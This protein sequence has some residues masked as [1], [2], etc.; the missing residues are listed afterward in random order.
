[1]PA[2]N[3]Y[4]VARQVTDEIF[5][6]GSYA[7]MNKHHPDPGVQ[8]TIRNSGANMAEVEEDRPFV[9]MASELKLL[10]ID[11]GL[12][13]GHLSTQRLVWSHEV[14]D[15]MTDDPPDT[16]IIKALD[17]YKRRGGT[18]DYAE[19]DF[20]KALVAEVERMCNGS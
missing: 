20:N 9:E 11:E 19:A 5:G 1:M 14:E 18:K 2:I 12:D 17:E 3:L 10:V 13:P 8:R 15:S 16:V 6:A 4:D 7:E